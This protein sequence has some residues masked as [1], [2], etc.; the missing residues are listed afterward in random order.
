MDAIIDFLCEDHF[1]EQ[2]RPELIFM[3]FALIWTTII[4]FYVHILA[5]NEC[6]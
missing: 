4:Y 3:V 2:E 6:D 1:Q 5:P